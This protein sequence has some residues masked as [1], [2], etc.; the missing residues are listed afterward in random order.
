M[1]DMDDGP[2]QIPLEDSDLERTITGL[3][4]SKHYDLVITHSPVG[5]YTSHRRHEE[6]GAN[7]IRLWY[8][9]KI[10]CDDMWLFAYDDNDKT[11]LPQARADADMYTVLPSSIW[12]KKYN[13]IT[14]AYGFRPD[15]FE[16]Q[17]TPRAESF[18]QFSDP[19]IAWNMLQHLKD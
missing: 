8:E 4:P 5:E 16:A 17:T 9:R 18:W 15:S 7:M 11:I 1:G 3:L 6:T 12:Q 13:I 2:D 10:N 19:A 14:E